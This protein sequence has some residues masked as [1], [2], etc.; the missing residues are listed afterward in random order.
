MRVLYARCALRRPN[1]LDP[2]G[3]HRRRHGHGHVAQC[4]SCRALY[5]FLKYQS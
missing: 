4:L 2:Q 3:R 1:P 5:S